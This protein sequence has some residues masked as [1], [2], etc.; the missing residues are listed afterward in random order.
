MTESNTNVFV[1]PTTE[2]PTTDNQGIVS[3][4]VGE[5]KKF[6]TVDDLARGKLEA[7]IY[8][9]SLKKKL[10]DSEAERA[11]LINTD[12]KFNQVLQ[13]LEQNKQAPSQGNTQVPALGA[14]DIADIVRNQMTLAEQQKTAE[15]NIATTNSRLN[16]LFGDK[17][18]EV[19]V[20]K[21]K[22][23]GISMADLQIISA[24]SPNA[25][26][27]MIGAAEST[28]KTSNSSPTGTVNTAADFSPGIKAGTK[29]YYV[30]LR[31][32]DPKFYEKY[33]PEIMEKVKKEGLI[34]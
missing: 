2:T 8:V 10:A 4:L 15:Q 7:D 6:K 11:K 28:P 20:S 19:V 5:G 25:F 18:K 29:E 3:Q 32:K 12:E 23:L 34:Y 9:E 26:L 14:S 24:K 21:A 16:E 1:E 17:A 33:M 30:E 22:A 31:K 27:T 13:Q